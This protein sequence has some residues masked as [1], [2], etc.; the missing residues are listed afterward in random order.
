MTSG[1]APASPCVPNGPR[2]FHR[3]AALFCLFRA[4]TPVRLC[5]VWRRGPSTTSARPLRS[6]DDCLFVCYHIHALTAPRLVIFGGPAVLELRRAMRFVP[7]AFSG[8]SNR[9][10]TGVQSGQ[11][12]AKRRWRR[13]PAT[14]TSC[15]IEALL[16]RWHLGILHSSA[17]ALG[18]IPFPTRLA[19]S[20]EV[21]RVPHG[22]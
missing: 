20:I 5:C 15:M 9:L 2:T 13:P 18:T 8:P 11:V 17:Q 6:S 16:E 1:C 4:T 10:S 3:K 19:W 14:E 12:G 22:P 7:K 21:G